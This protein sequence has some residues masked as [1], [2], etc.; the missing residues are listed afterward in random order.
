[1]TIGQNIV[2]PKT[3][4]R[5]T[6]LPRLVYDH[7]FQTARR[8]VQNRSDR[9]SRRAATRELSGAFRRVGMPY[10]ID[11]SAV[12]VSSERLHFSWF[13]GRHSPLGGGQEE[14]GQL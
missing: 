7:M 14:I 13:A 1:M 9:L 3:L 6:F 2:L 4:R 10:R 5:A 12:E 8:R 11:N